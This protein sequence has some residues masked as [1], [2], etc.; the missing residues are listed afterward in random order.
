[1]RKRRNRSSAIE[2]KV[3]SV[4]RRKS[5]RLDL[6]KE[7]KR[8]KSKFSVFSISKSFEKGGRKLTL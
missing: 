1:M 3:F 6:E 5:D 2:R 7:M 4:K 8:E